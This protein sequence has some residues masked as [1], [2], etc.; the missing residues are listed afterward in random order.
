MEQRKQLVAKIS[1][2]L[3]QLCTRNDHQIPPHQA[4]SPPAHARFHAATP[5]PIS[6]YKYVSRIAKY[7]GCSNEVLIL[8]MVYIDRIIVG[9]P[10]FRVNA[11][12]V[13]RLALTSMTVAAKFF[14][15]RYYSNRYYAQIGGLPV[16]ELNALEVEF[17][18]MLAFNLYVKDSHYFTYKHSLVG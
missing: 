16:T 7:S 3:S 8:A 11:Y 15:D 1:I 18:Y 14:D 5:P 13:H 4:K 6:I 12:T 9:N 17:L 2:V 10:S